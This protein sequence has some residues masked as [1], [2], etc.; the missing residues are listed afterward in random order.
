LASSCG[1]DYFDPA[2]ADTLIDP[3]R[4]RAE[5]RRLFRAGC[6]D[7]VRLPCSGDLAQ[8]AVLARP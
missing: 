7:L 6:D 3:K 5:L 2:R 4:I 1:D 8:V